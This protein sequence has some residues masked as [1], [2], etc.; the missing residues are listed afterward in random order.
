VQ[1]LEPDRALAGDHVGVVE[2][3]DQ[4]GAGVGRTLGG[5]LER[6]LNRAAAEA[7]VRPQPLD[8]GDLRDGR[9]AGHEDLA[10]DPREPRGLRDGARVVARARG[11]QPAARALA[12]RRHL[13]QRAAQLEGARRLQ[14]LGLQHDRAAGRLGE[15]LA[16]D[17]RRAHGDGR[18]R[19]AR[20]LQVDPGGQLRERR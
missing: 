7:H 18:D 3:V 6:L 14:R 8:R 5:Q 20:G 19:L 2:G 17:R 16:G 13:G 15:V 12:Q 9:V 10:A 1:Q 11:D 4:R